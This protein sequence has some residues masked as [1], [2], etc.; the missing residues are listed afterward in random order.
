MPISPSPWQTALLHEYLG[1]RVELRELTIDALENYLHAGDL[2]RE[3]EE[4]GLPS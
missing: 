2:Q 3:T 4:G 1:S